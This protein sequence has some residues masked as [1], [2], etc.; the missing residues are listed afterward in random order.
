MAKGAL[1]HSL[2]R[3]TAC[4]IQNGHQGGPKW[5]TGSAKVSTPRFLGFLETFALISFFLSEHSFYQKRLRQ[6][7]E[8]QKKTEEKKK[9][10]MI[11]KVTTTSLPAVK[12]LNADR[13]NTTCSCQKEREKR[14]LFLVAINVVASRPTE[15]RPIGTPHA[16]AKMKMT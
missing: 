14:M 11:R 9:K 1:A 16:R 4:K 10:R 6:R 5:P 7:G 8:K 3:R 2:Q 12:R 13:W 15:R